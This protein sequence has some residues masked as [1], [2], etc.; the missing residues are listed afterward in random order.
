[1]TIIPYP[2]GPLPQIG[3]GGV[4]SARAA[5]GSTAE[6]QTAVKNSY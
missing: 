6:K 4:D 1:M 2:P 3:E 5:C